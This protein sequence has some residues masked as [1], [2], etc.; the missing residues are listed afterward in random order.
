VNLLSKVVCI[1]II[2]ILFSWL[3]FYSFISLN[4]SE[5]KNIN[6]EE[7]GTWFFDLTT[8][9][10][11]ISLQKIDSISESENIL[12][13]K[14]SIADYLYSKKWSYTKT[15]TWTTTQ[16]QLNPGLYIFHLNEF[17]KQYVI[18]WE[19]FQ[20]QNTWPGIFLINSLDPEKILIFSLNTPLKLWL[21]YTDTKE[22]VTSLNLYPHTYITINLSYNNELNNTDLLR[23][24]QFFP[25]AYLN[26]P[27][28]NKENNLDIDFL[29]LFSSNEDEYTFIKNTFKY[30]WYRYKLSK[31]EVQKFSDSVFPPSPWEKYI[32]KYYELFLND[33]KK[34]IYNKNLVLKNL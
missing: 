11:S 10:D 26:T 2:F 32:K 34:E 9:D 14:L 4:S 24:S 20:L 22:I 3:I 27:L 7:I 28:T 1:I 31:E 6:I 5:I 33:E 18:N 8:L 13:E 30:I 23:I 25:L 16:L 19:W 17:N 29:T 21:I 15:S 12:V